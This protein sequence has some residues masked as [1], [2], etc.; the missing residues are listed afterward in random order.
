MLQKIIQLLLFCW[1]EQNHKS[2]TNF[3][4]SVTTKKYLSCEVDGIETSE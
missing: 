4:M 2:I 1:M 3:Y